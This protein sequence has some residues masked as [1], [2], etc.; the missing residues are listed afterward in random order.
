MRTKNF[1]IFQELCFFMLQILIVKRKSESVSYV[2][3]INNT[4][5][6]EI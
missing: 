6:Y 3:E 1:N 5:M 2:F 4:E